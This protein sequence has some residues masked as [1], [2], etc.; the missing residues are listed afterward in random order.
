MSIK[1]R[2]NGRNL[3][4]KIKENILSNH[5][6]FKNK[7]YKM[8]NNSPLFLEEDKIEKI[9]RPNKKNNKIIYIFNNKKYSTK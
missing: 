7:K 9:R 1:S 5:H 8:N 3:Q 4:N 2:N 6:N